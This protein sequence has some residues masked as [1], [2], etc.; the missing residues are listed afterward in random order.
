MEGK[1]GKV[2]YYLKHTLKALYR[3]TIFAQITLNTQ[4]SLVAFCK[5]EIIN[6][7]Y[8]ILSQINVFR[9]VNRLDP[10][11]TAPSGAVCSGSKLL[12]SDC[13]SNI[14]VKFGM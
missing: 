7:A 11:Q 10:E 6:S 3:F 8:T 12:A 1:N 14:L 5:E 9:M 13:C 4:H 2:R